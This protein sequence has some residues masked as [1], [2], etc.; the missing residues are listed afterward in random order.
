MPMIRVMMPYDIVSTV[1]PN[2]LFHRRGRASTSIKN[3]HLQPESPAT[4]R[5]WSSP[6]ARRAD[7]ISAMLIDVQKKPRRK[8]SS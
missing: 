8:E 7:R 4:P 3:S 5:M 6:Y 2:R 1:S